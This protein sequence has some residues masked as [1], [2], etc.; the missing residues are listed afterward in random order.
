MGTAT[1]S[2]SKTT[3]SFKLLPLV[4]RWNLKEITLRILL[5]TFLK[6]VLFPFSLQSTFFSLA[7]LLFFH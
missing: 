7:S 1:K 2:I 6:P 4:S 3:S 5:P